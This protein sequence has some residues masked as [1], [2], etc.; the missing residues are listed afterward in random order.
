MRPGVIDQDPAHHLR[1][2]PEKMRSVLPAHAILANQADI[3]LVYQR[4]RLKRVIRAL[5]P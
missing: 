3:S 1:R 2:Y 5:V 4:R